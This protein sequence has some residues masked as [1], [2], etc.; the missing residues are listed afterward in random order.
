VSS[1][2]ESTA[3]RYVIEHQRTLDVVVKYAPDGMSETTIQ[4]W[5]AVGEVVLA[6]TNVYSR[7]V[8]EAWQE[9]QDDELPFGRYRIIKHRP[10]YSEF[11]E[12]DVTERRERVITRVDHAQLAA[13]IETLS[14]AG[15]TPAPVPDRETDDDDGRHWDTA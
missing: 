7:D 8:L 6:D 4:A 15:L 13:D 2:N 12:W 5:V 10:A 11:Q 3:T 9:T 14:I 1:P